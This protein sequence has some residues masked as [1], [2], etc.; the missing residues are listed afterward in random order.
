MAETLAYG[1]LS[2]K[3]EQELSNVYGHDRVKIAFM[4]LCILVLW[5]K[6]SLVGLNEKIFIP[7]EISS[8]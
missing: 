3:T 6:V 8:S 7:R 1:Y 4:N 5:M 2:E